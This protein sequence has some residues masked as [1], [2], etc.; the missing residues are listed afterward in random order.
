[1]N[2]LFYLLSAMATLFGVG[3]AI[4]LFGNL[5]LHLFGIAYF[6]TAY[7]SAGILSIM[8]ALRYTFS[9]ILPDSNVANSVRLENEKNYLYDTNLG[10][11]MILGAILKYNGGEIRV[12]LYMWNQIKE[13]VKIEHT[14][15]Y[16]TK[17]EV[18]RL[19]EEDKNGE[20]NITE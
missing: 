2:N 14:S 12:P 15:D 8:I 6:L 17:E 4:F 20:S 1:M 13:D 18:F 9:F 19:V 7:Q 5:I 16:K 10:L 11:T 3:L